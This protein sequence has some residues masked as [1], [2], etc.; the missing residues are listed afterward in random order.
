V[1]GEAVGPGT[2]I[3]W[4][5]QQVLTPRRPGGSQ[6]RSLAWAPGKT[7]KVQFPKLMPNVGEGEF[8]FGNTKERGEEPTGPGGVR[9]FQKGSGTLP[10]PRVLLL[11][12]QIKSL[13]GISTFLKRGL[14]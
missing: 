10:N 12:D 5:E 2:K 1:V 11:C 6:A 3:A 8:Y 4:S 7:D 14:D 13:S 9:T